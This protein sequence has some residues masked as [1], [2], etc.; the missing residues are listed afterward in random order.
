MS[1]QMFPPTR[2]SVS[3]FVACV[4]VSRVSGWGLG[5]PGGDVV[6]LVLGRVVA[7]ACIPVSRHNRTFVPASVCRA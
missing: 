5:F 3:W 2:P 4:W 7:S 1:S 6:S